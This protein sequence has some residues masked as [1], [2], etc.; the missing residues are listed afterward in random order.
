M[1]VNNG[2]RTNRHMKQGCGCGPNLKHKP[3]WFAKHG[4][5][6]QCEVST[7]P[8]NNY[9]LFNAAPI[10]TK[11]RKGRKCGKIYGYACNKHLTEFLDPH[12]CGAHRKHNCEHPLE[13]QLAK[14]PTCGPRCC[15]GSY[16]HYI[17]AGYRAKCSCPHPC[18]HPYSNYK[19]AG[20]RRSKNACACGNDAHDGAFWPARVPAGTHCPARKLPIERRGDTS[21]SGYAQQLAFGAIAL[22]NMNRSGFGGCCAVGRQL[23][24]PS[25]P[26]RPAIPV[27][28]LPCSGEQDACESIQQPC[29]RR[30]ANQDRTRQFIS[31]HY[32][33]GARV[34]DKI[35]ED[36]C[37]INC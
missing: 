24:E 33:Y 10:F 22:V 18:Q 6:F 27:V 14:D 32:G 3:E 31:G 2:A 34:M 30:F 5:D 1:R 15:L 28:G 23:R 17:E 36:D 16:P 19:D 4:D 21:Q 20:V 7:L 12:S 9:Y 13:L 11:E 26:S 37:A 29:G 8:C 35:N 25:A